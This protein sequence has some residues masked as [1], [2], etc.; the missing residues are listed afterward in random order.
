MA[1]EI[2]LE[3]LGMCIEKVE[4]EVNAEGF[5]AERFLQA[6]GIN[7]V[8]LQNAQADN[9]EPYREIRRQAKYASACNILQSLMP[10]AMQLGNVVLVK[11]GSPACFNEIDAMLWILSAVLVRS[12]GMIE[13]A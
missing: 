4:E 10:R 5:N 8:Q 11:V 1:A 13:T 7:L 3:L 12:R 2:F 9:P 6:Q